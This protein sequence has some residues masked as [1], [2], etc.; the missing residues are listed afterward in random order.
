MLPFYKSLCEQFKWTPDE[1][2]VAQMKEA[3]DKK[4]EELGATIKDAQEN[5]G[6]SEVRE[7]LLA[8]AEFFCRIGERVRSP[9]TKKQSSPTKKYCH[10]PTASL[11]FYL[12]FSITA[13]CFPSLI[14]FFFCLNRRRLRLHS[15]R[16]PR[17]P[18]DWVRSWT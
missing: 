12:S 15:V 3:I 7:G 17:R 9:N 11:P 18:S 1:K 16:R 10:C 6:E 13:T 2:L 14:Y 4:V 5:L 8:R